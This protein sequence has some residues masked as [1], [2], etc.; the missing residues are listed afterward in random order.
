MTPNRK[1]DIEDIALYFNINKVFSE[2]NQFYLPKYLLVNTLCFLKY[3][4]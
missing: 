4:E 3:K 2:K 1:Y